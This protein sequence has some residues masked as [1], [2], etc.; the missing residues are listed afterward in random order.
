MRIGINAAARLRNAGEVQKL[1]CPRRGRAARKTCLETQDR[2]DLGAHR[3]QG[4][5]GRHGFLEN[6]RD[7]PAKKGTEPPS[8]K[9]EKLGVLEYHR[10]R[11]DRVAG[12]ES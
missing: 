1:L 4:I 9:C 8:G 2:A 6:H 11:D 12:Q 10:T 7:T 5:E 3:K